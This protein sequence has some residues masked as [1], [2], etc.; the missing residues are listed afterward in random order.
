MLFMVLQEFLVN[1]TCFGWWQ[2]LLGWFTALC[3]FGRVHL[4]LAWL[5][6]QRPM[7]F[8]LQP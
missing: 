1:S 7:F 8:N 4:L 2:F 5:S 6:M 3:A